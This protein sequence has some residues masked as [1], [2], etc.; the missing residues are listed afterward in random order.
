[1]CKKEMIKYILKNAKKNDMI[2]IYYNPN[3]LKS[4]LEKQS[5]NYIEE[6]YEMI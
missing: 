6:L 1:M 3:N 4:W 5:D 2:I